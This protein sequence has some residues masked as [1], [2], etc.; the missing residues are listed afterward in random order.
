METKK[1]IDYEPI[2]VSKKELYKARKL[3]F[4]GS[5]RTIIQYPNDRKLNMEIDHK[6]LFELNEL[7]K[8]IDITTYDEWGKYSLLWSVRIEDFPFDKP[9]VKV[10]DTEYGL[11]YT[12]ISKLKENPDS[13]EVPYIRLTLESFHTYFG[14]GTSFFINLPD[15][16]Y[17]GYNISK[18]N[19]RTIE[20]LTQFCEAMAQDSE[21]PLNKRLPTTSSELAE[22]LNKFRYQSGTGVSVAEFIQENF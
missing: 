4:T 20:G 18:L 21:I 22:V 16:S 6:V 8:T 10:K 1:Y 12:S 2:V 3:S 14:Y 13:S 9:F 17:K 7:S 15:M 5:I 19:I 11:A